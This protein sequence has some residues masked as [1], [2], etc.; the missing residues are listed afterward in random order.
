LRG[1]PTIEASQTYQPA[2]S[3]VH[4]LY[5]EPGVAALLG[6]GLW[7]VGA[8][9]DVFLTPGLSGVQVGGAGDSKAAFMANG[10]VGVKF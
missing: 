2:V 5:V 3:D 10:Q 7:F 9:V 6:F 1:A 8:D 4:N